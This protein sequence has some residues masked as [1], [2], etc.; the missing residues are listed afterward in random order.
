MKIIINIARIILN[1]MYGV[2][3]LFP[4]KN[5]VVLISRQFD[6]P[7]LDFRMLADELKKTGDIEVVKLCRKI[8]P[9]IGGKISYCFHMLVQMKEMATAKVV[10]LDSYCILA[11]LLKHKDSLTI[12]QMWHALGSMKK[13]GKSIVGMD[14][15]SSQKVAEAMHMHENYDII[16]SSCEESSKY[17]A[18]AF[19]YSQDI[20]KIMSLPRVDAILSKKRKTRKLEAIYEKY[21]QLI[22]EKVVLYA[23]TLRKNLDITEYANKLIKVFED[24]EYKLVVKLHPLTQGDLEYGTAI[25]DRSFTTLDMLYV[26]DYVITDYSAIMYEAALANKP[27]YFYAFDYNT[28]TEGRSFYIDYEKL[29][30][31]P[32]LKEPDQI[33]ANILKGDYDLD[34]VRAFANKYIENQNNCTKSLANLVRKNM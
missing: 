1:L 20:V 2:C 32:I 13:F 16:L 6:K 27:M 8:P 28:Y 4:Q 25:N 12:I 11:S 31:G 7:S 21:P 19:G 23:P 29:A 33:V 24:T 14:E 34:R 3:K 15:G 18:E 30:P 26:A 9:G 5:K 22:G 10:V 17:F